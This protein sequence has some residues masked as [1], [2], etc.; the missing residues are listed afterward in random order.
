VKTI[1][2]QLVRIVLTGLL[3]FPSARA[4]DS[5]EENHEP[6]PYTELVLAPHAVLTATTSIGTMKIEAVD[7]LTRT[8]TWE[9]ASR[10]VRLWP[11]EERWYGSLGAYYPGPGEHWE[12]HHGITRGVLEEGRQN[13]SSESEALA[14]LHL[15]MNHLMV[16]RDDGLAV[17][18]S[19][20]LDR[21][22]L[23]VNVWQILINGEKPHHLA[24]SQ[25][26]KITLSG[27][28]QPMGR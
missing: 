18:W 28:E 12:N 1:P 26:D 22:Q 20:N 24:G 10:S 21:R 6:Y 19:K 9:G 17:D 7:V 8:Y 4:D 27:K 23:N 16:Y 2:S 25:N 11:R 15:G 13:F 14:W 3:L 5:P